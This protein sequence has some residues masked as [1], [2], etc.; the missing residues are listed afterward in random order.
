[1]ASAGSVNASTDEHPPPAAAAFGQHHGRQ[2]AD[3]KPLRY[4]SKDGPGLERLDLGELA[5]D[6][7]PGQAAPAQ[8]RFARPTPQEPDDE[9][10]L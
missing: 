10:A 1:V 2:A 6:E 5:E 9:R 7:R 8:T 4:F 3:A